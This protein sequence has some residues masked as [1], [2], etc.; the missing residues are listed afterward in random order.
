MDS[1]ESGAATHRSSL[2]SFLGFRA[3]LF[4]ITGVTLIFVLQ[5]FYSGAI[6]PISNI[7]PAACATTAF[8]SAFACARRY[9][10]R[11]RLDFG[12]VWFLFSLGTGLWS[13]AE[14]T[15]AYYYFVLNTT[16]PYPSMADIFYVGGYLP[17]IAALV[18]Y[19]RTF[20]VSPSRRRKAYAVL[21]IGT[22]VAL[23]L[24]FVLPIELSTGPSLSQFITDMTYPVLDLVLF[25]L[26]VLSLAVFAGGRIA[27]WWMLFGAGSVMY[28]IADE[29]FLYQVAHG[30]Y[31][32]GSL[33]DLIFLLG[34][35][36]FALAFYAHR[37]EF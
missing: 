12:S 16:I 5:P 33:D 22:G 29:Y 25:T 36:T 20:H 21:A 14:S 32:N 30:S 35:L 34:Y 9:G 7:L 17:I 15:W 10:V 19:L 23:A 11:F 4:G 26:T 2:L 13:I 18:G 3:W 37:K 24:S 27:K 1:L 28:V 31:Y 6:G 8:A